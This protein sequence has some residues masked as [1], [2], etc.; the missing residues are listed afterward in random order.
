[1]RLPRFQRFRRVSVC[2]LSRQLGV[3]EATAYGLLHGEG[4]AVLVCERVVLC[5]PVVE[6][7][8]LL[9]GVA[10]KVKWLNCN[11][12]AAQG[13]LQEAPEVLDSVRVDLPPDVLLKVI[14][15]FVNEIP[16]F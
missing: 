4:K 1:M 15:G 10:V 2:P 5:S 3:G 9:G 7:E 6:P 13:A 8:N 12:G 11:V 16:L 14:H